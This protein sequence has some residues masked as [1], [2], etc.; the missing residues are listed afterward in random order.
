VPRIYYRSSLFLYS[1]E[2]GD[3]TPIIEFWRATVYTF[4]RPADRGSLRDI[5]EEVKGT[6]LVEPKNETEAWEEEQVEP[7]ES[8]GLGFYWV[9]V[10]R[11]E[12][13]GPN[14][15]SPEKRVEIVHLPTWEKAHVRRGYG[16]LEEWASLGR[17]VRR[18]FDAMASLFGGSAS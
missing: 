2:E 10:S 15:L 16:L 12:R 1:V 4:W 6:P 13:K 18:G 7:S 17:A 3:S 8:A 14:L 9:E 5:L 11:G